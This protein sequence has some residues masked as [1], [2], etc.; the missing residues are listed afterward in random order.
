MLHNL[1]L[2]HLRFC[3]LNFFLN[4]YLQ[5]CFTTACSFYFLIVTRF[6]LAHSSTVVVRDAALLSYTSYEFNPSKY[7]TRTTTQVQY[8]G[9]K[10]CFYWKASSS[11][12][13]FEQWL[14]WSHTHWQLNLAKVYRAH[15]LKICGYQL[16]IGVICVSHCHRQCTHTHSLCVCTYEQQNWLYG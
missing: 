5:L 1:T 2:S 13:G 10:Y 15:T 3:A 8:T 16:F 11:I 12:I 14:H 4:G 7:H 9:I 6:L